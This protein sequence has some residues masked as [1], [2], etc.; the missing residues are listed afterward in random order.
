MT[1]TLLDFILLVI[2]AFFAFA[3]FWYGLIKSLGSLAGAV[4]GVILASNY[5]QWLANFAEKLPFHLSENTARIIAWLL[6]FIVAG[7]LIMFVFW[8][9]DKVFKAL[10]IIPFLKTINRMAGLILGLIEGALV[11][12][13]GLIFLAKFPF[14]MFLQPAITTSQIALWLINFG[15][16][17]MP[18]LPEMFK[19]VKEIINNKIPI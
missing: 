3:G 8:M 5:F 17:V 16:I 18:L 9:I 19:E 15:G 7:R 12:G 1:L 13:V 4:V 11:I 14:A 10:S 2:L 6:I